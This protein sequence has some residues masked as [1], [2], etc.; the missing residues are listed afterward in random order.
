MKLISTIF[1]F[2]LLFGFGGEPTFA[3][4]QS[5]I[6]QDLLEVD[7]QRCMQGCVPGFGEATCKPLCDC[8]VKEFGKRLDFERYLDVAAELA[9]NEIGPETRKILDSIAQY[10]AAEIEK[11]G[12]EVGESP[13]GPPA[14]P[15]GK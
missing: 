10:C 7:R 11:A 2:V 15:S 6:P 9:K 1:L 13:K 3:Q 5:T 8:T 14:P 4:E 12:I